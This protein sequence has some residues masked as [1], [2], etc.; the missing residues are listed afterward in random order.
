MSVK[1]G[2]GVYLFLKNGVLGLELGLGLGL[3]LTL[4]CERQNYDTAVK[5]YM[6]RGSTRVTMGG[7]ECFKNWFKA[8][9]MY[10]IL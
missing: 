6:G 10:I 7:G 3:T 1:C 9:N 4:T 5:L 2:V 8:L